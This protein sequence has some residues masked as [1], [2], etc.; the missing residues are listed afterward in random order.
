MHDGRGAIG[1]FAVT[2]ELE[3]C[4]LVSLPIL[5]LKA[6]EFGLAT[7]R[8]PPASRDM[9]ELLHERCPKPATARRAQ[10]EVIEGV[11]SELGHWPTSRRVTMMRA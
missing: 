5:P 9:L 7:R 11:M 8:L 2:E 3:T 10:E 6:Q 1:R 4:L